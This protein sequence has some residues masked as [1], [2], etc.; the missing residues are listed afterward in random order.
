MFHH[1]P[2]P[3]PIVITELNAPPPAARRYGFRLWERAVLAV[4]PLSVPAPLACCVAFGRAGWSILG[5]AAAPAA[6]VFVT[7]ARRH[8]DNAPEVPVSAPGWAASWSEYEGVVVQGE[9][10]A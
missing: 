6:A 7:V 2:Q 9:R 4:A 5:L 1:N 10:A 8:R 3:S